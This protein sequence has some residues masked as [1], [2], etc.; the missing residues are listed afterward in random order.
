MFL[1]I[2][3]GN[4]FTKIAVFDAGELYELQNFN[5]HPD[6]QLIDG[7]KIFISSL[8][9]KKINSGIFSTVARSSKF[10]QDFLKSITFILEMSEQC[11]LPV[12]NAYGTP[13]TLGNDRIASVVAATNMFPHENILCIDAGTCITYDFVNNQSEYLGGGISPGIQ[14]RLKALHTFTG[15]L[16]LVSLKPEVELIGN[17]TESSILSGVLNGIKAELEGIIQRY[18]RENPGL[19][20]ILTGGDAIYFDKKVKSNIFAVPN[21]VLMGLKDILQYNVER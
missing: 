21:L 17:T 16:P 8:E 5:N 7:I 1:V 10:L 19:K 14:M 2:D 12:K 13:E 9:P 6:D 15:K 18:L 3:Q 4:S 11:K 20:I